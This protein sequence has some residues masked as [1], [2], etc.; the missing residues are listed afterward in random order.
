MRDTWLEILDRVFHPARPDLERCLSERERHAA[1]RR[2][3]AEERAR[4]IADC[5]RRINDARR[6]VFETNDGVVT[7]RMTDLEREWRRLSRQDPED[8]LMDLWARVA[9]ASWIDRKRWRGCAPASRVDAAIALAADAENVEAAEEALG[10]L[11]SALAAHGISVGPLIRWRWFERDAETVAVLLREPL[12]A[13]CE[14][15]PAADRASIFA[16]ARRFEHGILQKALA[17]FP[18]RPLLARELGHAAF[19]DFLWRAA[20]LDIARN[21]VAALRALWKTGYVLSEA[22]AKSVTLEIPPL[23]GSA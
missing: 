14:A 21:P 4:A 12:R 18:E 15:C 1:D 6:A 2:V 16:R 20:P 10:A 17:R 13:A 9:P 8:G 7:S 3:F 22:D 23:D 19:V 11:R 5:E